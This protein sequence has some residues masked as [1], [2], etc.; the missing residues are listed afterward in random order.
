MTDIVK[1][2][3]EGLMDREIQ[4]EQNTSFYNESFDPTQPTTELEELIKSATDDLNTEPK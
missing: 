2:T 4:P 3:T 1:D